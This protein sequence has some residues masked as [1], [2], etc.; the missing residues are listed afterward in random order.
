MK[1]A[2]AYARF[3]TANQQDTSIE[4]QLEDIRN[5]CQRKGYTIVNEY[6]DKAESGAKEDRPAFQQMLRDAKQK[7][8]DVVVVHKI[9]RLARDRYLS[10]VTAHELK[11]YGITVESVLE[12]IGDDPIGQLLWGILDAVNEFERLNTAQEVKLK[13]RPLA[14]KGFWLGGKIPYGFDKQ[15]VTSEDGKIHYKLVINE[16]EAQIIRLIFDLFVSGYSFSQIANKLNEMGIKFRDRKPTFSNIAEIV[17]NS[18]YVG[19]HFYGKGTKTNHRITRQDAIYVKDEAII[20]ETTW[21]KAQERLKRYVKGRHTKHNYWLRGIAFCECGAELYG[22]FSQT[23]AYRC[24]NYKQTGTHVQI[25]ANKLEGYIEGF[26]RKQ[27]SPETIDFQRLA[28]SLNEYMKEFDSTVNVQELLQKQQEY[29]QMIQNLTEALA[30]TPP[31][32]QKTILDKIN[33]FSNELEKINEEIRKASKER[34][35]YTAEELKELYGLLRD[36]LESDKEEVAKTLI[37]RITVYKGGYIEVKT[38]YDN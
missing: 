2:V 26:L 31:I 10:V 30:K 23:P 3:S 9:N 11:R 36:R 25:S 24:R 18:R 35:Q 34:K 13:V 4:K 12:P 38:K 21:Q 7:L 29:M 32:A 27:L 16:Q 5:Y 22:C 19:L 28:D 15:A 1:R 6:I 8:F 17:K 33:E 37:E 14:Q 20:D